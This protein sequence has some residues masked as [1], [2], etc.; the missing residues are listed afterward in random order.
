MKGDDNNLAGETEAEGNEGTETCGDKEGTETLVR[1]ALPLLITQRSRRETE[2][3]RLSSMRMTTQRQLCM[4]LGQ[5]EF[6]PCCGV[7]LEHDD[8]G[9]I[10]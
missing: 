8:K 2:D 1:H 6:T 4:T 10:G 9:S 7:M 3:I 5:D